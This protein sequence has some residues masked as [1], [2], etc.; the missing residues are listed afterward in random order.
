MDGNRNKASDE[1]TIDQRFQIVLADPPWSYNDKAHAGQRGVE[2]HYDSMELPDIKGLPIPKL[3][4]PDSVLYLWATPPMLKEAFAVMEAWGYKYKTVA[5]VWVKTTKLGKLAWGMGNYSRANAEVVLIG[6]KGKGVP[7]LN[8]GVHQVVRAERGKHSS[9][10]DEVQERIER[11]HG[12]DV[13]RV[14]LFARRRR[15]GW[16]AWGNDV[17]PDLELMNGVWRRIDRQVEEAPASTAPAPSSSRLD[18][19]DWLIGAAGE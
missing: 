16:S 14:E 15:K 12:P 6:V 17:A 9:K 19:L 3:A 2:Y 18:F 11:L 4:A 1:D 13:S 10:P 8:H 7:V 5:F